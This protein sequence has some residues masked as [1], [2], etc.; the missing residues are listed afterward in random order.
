MMYVLLVLILILALVAGLYLTLSWSLAETPEDVS[1]ERIQEPRSYYDPRTWA[2][3]HF[4]LG[5]KPLLISSRRDRR[6]RFRK[7][8]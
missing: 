3:Y 6:G 7:M 8:R 5:Q 2:A 1:D 4:L